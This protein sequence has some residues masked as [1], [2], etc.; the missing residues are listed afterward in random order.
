MEEKPKS[1][2]REM[3]KWRGNGGNKRHAVIRFFHYEIYPYAMVVLSEKI[4]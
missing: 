1:D 2:R 3:S 4:D